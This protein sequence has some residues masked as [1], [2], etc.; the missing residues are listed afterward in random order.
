MYDAMFTDHLRWQAEQYRKALEEG[1]IPEG[2][3][4]IHRDDLDRWRDATPEEWAA[5]TL[6][7]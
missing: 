5:G 6:D 1:T 3:L 7:A 4:V 2:T